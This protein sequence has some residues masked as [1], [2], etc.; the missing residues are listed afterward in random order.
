MALAACGGGGE[1]GQ[2]APVIHEVTISVTG[3]GAVTAPTGVNCRSTCTSSVNQGTVLSVS[4]NADA[5]QRFVE[6]GGGCSGTASSCTVTVGARLTITARFEPVPPAAGWRDPFRVQ[7]GG[8]AEPVVAIDGSSR[9]VVAWRRLEGV[10]GPNQLLA[11]RGAAAGAFGAPERL[12]TA[13]GDVTRVRL[14]V[15]R[16]SGRG[17][18]AWTQTS[19]VVDLYARVL[20]PAAGWGP[21]ILLENLPG[22]VGRISVGVDTGGNAMAVWSQIGPSVRFSIY[23]S[24]YTTA[25]GWTTPVLLESNEVVGTSDADPVVAVTPAGDAVAVWKRSTG[26]A[27]ELWS[28]RYSPATGWGTASLLVADAGAAQTL[29]AHDL[30]ADAR[31]DA[32]L[33]WGQGDVVSGAIENGIWFKR[34][35]SGVW[36]SSSTRVA[37]PISLSQGVISTPF[38]RMNAAGA[39]LVA[40]VEF[41]TSL[42][43]ASAPAGAGFG[44]VSVVRP[45][46]MRTWADP[47]AIGI[48]STSGGWAIWS[49]PDTQSIG[50]AQ[51]VTGSAWSPS[52]ALESF[53]EPSLAPALAVNESG[54]A[55]LAWS[56][57]FPGSGTEIVVRQ[58]VS[59]R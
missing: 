37:R 43:V 58:Y 24:R 54:N 10:A 27:G 3:A 6:W 16:S 46:G 39:A 49:D 41:D 4:A 15:D 51:L 47:P 42:S 19:S 26:T 18:I 14:A 28:N 34:F 50:A 7:G 1:S 9:S 20:D 5:G 53:A 52:P 36:Q 31:G 30:M 32:V 17:V 55:V 35:V 44:G 23:A 38:L 2:G 22:V 57:L 45:A 21:A 11:M 33:V 29:G 8:A 13:G 48:D 56:Q 40:W 59:G 12:D 25:G